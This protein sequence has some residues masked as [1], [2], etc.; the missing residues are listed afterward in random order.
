MIVKATEACNSNCLYCD[1]VHKAVK[2]PTTMPLDVIECLFRRANEF[3]EETP[4]EELNVVWHGGEPLLLGPG[5]Y[6]QALEF[7]RRHCHDTSARI[8]HSIQTNLSL[9]TS[10]FARVFRELGIDFIGTSYDPI[11][12][13]RGPGKPPDTAIYNARFLR[14]LEVVEQ[15]GFGWGVI[16]VVTQFTLKRPDALFYFMTNLK[17]DGGISFSP[18]L[19]YGPEP[20]HLAIT[21]EEYA[22]FLGTIF[23][24]WWPHSE[25]FRGVEPFRSL[26]RNAREGACSLGCGESGQC[27]ASHWNLAPDGR[28]SHCGRSHDWG[29]LDY[30]SIFDR[31]L[32][33]MRRDGQ[34]DIL[35]QRNEVLTNGDCQGCRLWLI[36]HGGCPLD[37][38]AA[39]GSFGHKTPW[40]RATKRFVETHFEP[41]TGLRLKF[42][43]EDGP[44]GGSE[45]LG[46]TSAQVESTP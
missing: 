18:V 42:S 33:D 1:V 34:R 24:L 25:R 10:E 22:D 26:L 28:V 37:S 29:L 12:G 2:G 7:Q 9:F 14:G 27:A 5:S 30:G 31:S 21:P 13:V 4:N 35:A 8:H 41:V 39:T 44:L 17:P 40:C 46:A 20:R 15:E 45:P 16:Y 43:V 19:V 23:R 38:W 36:C 6:A 3:L 32:A 11:G